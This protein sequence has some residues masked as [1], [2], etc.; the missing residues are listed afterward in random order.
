MMAN[1]VLQGQLQLEGT[2]NLQAS[3]GGT[4]KVGASEALVVG[5][6]GV[7]V[8]ILL[9]G[10]PQAPLDDGVAV[11]VTA[12]QNRTVRAGGKLLVAGG[13]VKQGTRETWPGTMLPSQGNQ[14]VRIGAALINVVGDQAVISATGTLV[15][16]STS[17][18][19]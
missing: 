16:L 12:S 4:V 3:S 14:A 10:P 17:G 9:P 2:L 19:L 11:R 5:G 15:T 6:G 8:P 7:A 1:L 18:Q 13:T